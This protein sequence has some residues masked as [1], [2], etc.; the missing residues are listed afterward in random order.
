MAKQLGHRAAELGL[1]ADDLKAVQE[2][3]EALKRRRAGFITPEMPSI[4]TL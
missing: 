4:S 2:Y 3:T 1:D